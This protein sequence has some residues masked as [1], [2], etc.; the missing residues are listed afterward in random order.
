MNSRRILLS[1]CAA[2]ITLTVAG[3]AQIV[4]TGNINPFAEAGGALN[5]STD[6]ALKATA[7]A[8]GVYQGGVTYPTH[9]VP[10]GNNGTYGNGSSWLG[11]GGA[12]GT[13]LGMSWGNTGQTIQSIA[14]S[15]DA[16]LFYGDRN[17]GL[18]TFQYT[19]ADLTSLAIPAFGNGAGIIG[20]GGAAIPWTNIGTVNIQYPDGSGGNT[21]L[22]SIRHQFNLGYALS[23]VTGIRVLAPT[24]AVID[25]LE[26]YS[27]TTNGAAQSSKLAIAATAGYTVKWDGADGAYYNAADPA[28]IANIP[29]RTNL[30]LAANGG[31]AVASSV[32]GVAPHAIAGLND[33]LYGNS[34]SW[35]GGGTNDNAGITFSG[36]RHVGGVAWGRDNGNTTGTDCCGG[37]A[38]DRALGLYTLQTLDPVDGT[39]WS[40]VA[41]INYTGQDDA[42]IGGGFTEYLRH[43]YSLAQ[44]GGS[45]TS[46]GLRLVVP[47]GTAIDELEIYGST[48]TWTNGASTGLWA[49]NADA[50]FSGAADG[51]FL[52][53]DGANFGEAGAGTVT[54]SG[55]LTAGPVKVNAAAN[56]TFTGAG[57]LGGTTSLSKDGTGTL[58]LNGAHSYSGA[59]TVTGGA[60]QLDFSAAGA[61]AANILN[62]AANSSA[63]VLGGS[64]L[65]L[66]GK[67]NATNAQ[68]FAGTTL[69]AGASTIELAANATANP[70]ALD[71]GAVTRNAGA[72]VEFTLPAGTASG[73][74]GVV[75]SSG[76][77]GAILSDAG[78]AYATIGKS[79]W[80]AQAVG[81]TNLVGLS[82]LAGGYT[83]STAGALAGNANIASGVNT[84]VAASAV[85]SSLRFNQNEART[86]TVAGGQTLDTGGI[87]VTPAVA[88]AGSAITG[89]TLRGP[90]GKDLVIFQN[91]GQDFTIGSAIADNG[92][93]TGLT[94]AGPG[95]LVL[96]SLNSFSGNV[97][98]SGGTLTLSASAS[99]TNSTLGINV[100]G[101]TVTF[102]PGTTLVTTIT[103][104]IDFQTGNTNGLAIK[105]AGTWENN[106]ANTAGTGFQKIDN[107][108]LVGATI[109]DRGQHGGS[110]G[111]ILMNGKVVV[112]GNT[113]STYNQLGTGTGLGILST[114]FDVADVTGDAAADFTVNGVIRPTPINATSNL[115]K[116]GT[117]TM[118]LTR[119]NTYTGST[120]VMA[121]KLSLQGTSTN[122]LTGG[123]FI[124]NGAILSADVVSGNNRHDISIAV[125][126]TNVGVE[127]AGG[128]LAGNSNISDSNTGH[129]LLT[130]PGAPKISVSG[131][132]MSTISAEVH[133]NGAH[134]IDVADGA[135]PI[136]LLVTGALSHYH[137]VAW[138]GAVKTGAGT[139]K[140]A[141]SMDGTNSAGAAGIYGL[142]GFQLGGG[143]L[144]FSGSLGYSPF[145]PASKGGFYLA[146]FTANSVLKWDTGNTFDPSINAN[147]R[148]G[149]AVTASFDTN[150][151]NVTF[152]TA[153]V[154]G[155]LSTGALT[156]LGAGTLRLNAASGYTGTTTV[157]E[158]TLFVAST[159]SLPG[160]NIV[161]VGLLGTLTIDGTMKTASTTTVNGVLNGLGTLGAVT[162]NSTGTLS[163]GSGIQTLHTGALTFNAGSTLSLDLGMTTSDMVQSTAAVTLSGLTNLSLILTADPQDGTLFKI[164]DGAAPLNG[165]GLL[166]IGAN[167]L[168]Q[169]ELFHV[170][171]GGFS[172]D[173]TITYT[174][175]DG[176]DVVLNAVPEPTA[177]ASML[178][179]LGVLLARRRRR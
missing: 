159:G 39:T 131:N 138:G 70:L 34:N 121:G 160:T 31:T 152:G 146:D 85:I 125:G 81:K 84:T 172:Q 145:A 165:V 14:F 171:S 50:N 74:N 134:V 4:V 126:S 123:I 154:N 166:A 29:G 52:A 28:T 10:G 111:G 36:A 47:D 135:A 142:G 23:G 177:I 104:A 46:K 60:L 13:Y 139:M 117:G 12:G 38:T 175:G 108:T 110:L 133:F 20:A 92:T 76:A 158:G 170:D 91:S 53:Y 54:L 80:A 149:N 101:R 124:G 73:T 69:Q 119:P 163:P 109:N 22:G 168:A 1:S 21:T 8:D 71:L 122:T 55:V 90:A 120:E 115:T 173:F 161:N 89:G 127:I 106:P 64:R 49:T 3:R 79:D 72:T 169:G 128:T 93:A 141:S 43:E 178:G 113:P 2:L 75:T 44:V 78:V 24:G 59:T 62:Q 9:T 41:T 86:V 48:M 164:L 11:E 179:G 151:N 63:L 19:T 100:P 6:L 167:D 83:D 32:I 35:I 37:Q 82:S 150:G 157:S 27:G 87:L 45:L 33:G 57:S 147:L 107:L 7:F 118:V 136:D 153:I 25:E 67:A 56:Y 116:L 162:M 143:T 144:I 95:N 88:T 112:S 174:G 42:G 155:T 26:I 99:A 148:I 30:A 18:Y 94:K 58:T 103:D 98:V 51:K 17:F 137:T 61:P 140:L 15:R 132:T 40:N 105:L 68:R 77:D 114:S 156:K 96:P 5:A 102:A 129:F 16:M 130:T 65:L 97:L 176:N 66:T